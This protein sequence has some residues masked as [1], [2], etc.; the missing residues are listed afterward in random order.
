ML[1]PLLLLL[2]QVQN[3]QSRTQLFADIMLYAAAAPAAA[4]AGAG[5][6]AASTRAAGAAGPDCLLTSCC[7]LLPLLLLLQVQDLQ[8]RIQH[9]EQERLDLK[10]KADDKEERAAKVRGPATIP[11]LATCL[12]R[13]AACSV[14][15]ESACLQEAGPGASLTHGHAY[16]DHADSPHPFAVLY[17]MQAQALCILTVVRL[18]GRLLAAAT[19]SVYLRYV[20]RRLPLT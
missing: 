6:S 20:L 5:P 3:L 17:V 2:L 1:L 11:T 9:E 16:R 12:S 19:T 18:A 13:S 4:A 7:M 8:L 15:Q 14:Q 10:R